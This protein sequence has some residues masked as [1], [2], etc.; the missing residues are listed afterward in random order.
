MPN[1]TTGTLEG[2]KRL[3]RTVVGFSLLLLGMA[4]IFLPGPSVLVI[5]I[6]LAILAGE[7]VWARKLLRKFNAHVEN[8]FKNAARKAFD[9]NTPRL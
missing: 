6:A 7:F 5:P 2:A 8:S 9:K 1:F 3:I 4:L